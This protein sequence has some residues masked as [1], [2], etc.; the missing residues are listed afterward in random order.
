[1]RKGDESEAMLLDHTLQLYEDGMIHVEWIDG[2]PLFSLTPEARIL[3][4]VLDKGEEA[5]L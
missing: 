3:L 4:D 5:K 1:M 2:E